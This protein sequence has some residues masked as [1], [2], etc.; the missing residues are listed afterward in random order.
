MV[1]ATICNGAGLRAVAYHNSISETED[2]KMKRRNF[3]AFLTGVTAAVGSYGLGICA[4]ELK[5][6]E[7]VV[8]GM[9]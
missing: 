4:Q 3:I 2:T 9:T 6:A 1:E 8:T 5:E 7:L